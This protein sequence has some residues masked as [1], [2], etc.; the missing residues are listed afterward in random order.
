MNCKEI[1]EYFPAY[2][3]GDAGDEVA[4]RI[5]TH[6]KDCEACGAELER[7]REVVEG[8]R[9]MEEL[10][11]PPDFLVKVREK[12]EK[13]SAL[14]RVG[15]FLFIPW[16]VKVPVEAL[17]LALILVVFAYAFQFMPG[18]MEVPLSRMEAPVVDREIDGT[19]MFGDKGYH[20]ELD[21]YSPGARPR[22]PLPGEMG[23]LAT[24]PEAVA[25]EKAPPP[26]PMAEMAP[27]PVELKKVAKA[28][29][30]QRRAVRAEGG[31]LL[32]KKA[33]EAVE[34]T[35]AYRDRAEALGSIRKL[36]ADIDGEVLIEADEEAPEA[37]K[38]VVEVA[39]ARGTYPAFARGIRELRGFP[40]AGA[41]HY[42]GRG[43]MARKRG[44]MPLS[45]SGDMVSLVKE[46]RLEDSSTAEGPV[47][48]RILLVPE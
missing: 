15:S 16:K 6:L 12:I 42:E 43:L 10:D 46:R 33:G 28:E 32:S 7:L 37:G 47:R 4:V 36:I 17:S 21:E 14:K 13:G 25:K 48:V 45:E 40:G 8:L 24:R 31:V 29:L 2:I 23:R 39:V 27:A 9:S 44:L 11:V 20:E 3:D 35:L 26:E 34:M 1:R 38:D 5:R 30:A 18:E 22:E 19:V 41:S